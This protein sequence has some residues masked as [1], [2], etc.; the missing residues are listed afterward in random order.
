MG[1]NRKF[2]ILPSQ[3]EPENVILLEESQKALEDYESLLLSR[4]ES[5]LFSYGYTL[6]PHPADIKAAENQ[7]HTDKVR[8]QLLQNH[9]RLRF[10]L[11]KP[12]FGVEVS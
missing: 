7:F 3:V 2:V 10:L 1:V 12:R 8:L 4:I 11:E 6:N 5:E 9:A